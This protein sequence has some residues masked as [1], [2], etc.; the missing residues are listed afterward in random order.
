[1]NSKVILSLRLY[2][3]S[4]NGT[5]WDGGRHW[6]VEMYSEKV[7]NALGTART[8]PRVGEMPVWCAR[9]KNKKANNFFFFFKNRDRGKRLAGFLWLSTVAR[10]YGEHSRGKKPKRNPGRKTSP[11]GYIPVITRAGE[12]FQR[13]PC[14]RLGHFGNSE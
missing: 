13:I 12:P 6:T 9:E 4:N 5:K 8:W 2:S 11:R 3:N 1:M 14:C 7:I 10:M